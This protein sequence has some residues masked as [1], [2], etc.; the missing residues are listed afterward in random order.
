MEQIRLA[1]ELYNLTRERVSQGVAAELD[2]VRA[3]QPI[4]SLEQQR[5]EAEHSY[6]ST[7]LNLANIFQA[8]VTADFEVSDNAAYGQGDA[9]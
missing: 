4:N 6:I 1:T 7:K 2:A 9:S 5:Q 8:K 3:M